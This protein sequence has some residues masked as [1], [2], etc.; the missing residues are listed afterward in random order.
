[1]E[2]LSL[3]NRRIVTTSWDD[4]DR[5]DLKLAELLQSK[6]I[7]ATFYVPTGSYRKQAL[8]AAD[9][10]VLSS[11]GFEI[12]AHGFSHKLLKGLSAR[13]LEAEI[14]S[15]KP[16][17][18][19]LTG[20]E[21]RMFCYPCGQYDANAIRAVK[22]AGYSGA[23][24]VRMLAT[25]HDFDSFRMPTTVQSFP[26]PRLTYL[27]NAAKAGKMEGLRVCL[28]NGTRLGNWLELGKKLFD[29]VVEKGGIWHLYGH[30]WEIEE[31]GLWKDLGELLDYV[32][33]RSDVTYV[34]N[35]KLVPGTAANL[36]LEKAC[37]V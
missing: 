2:T 7:R 3:E 28:A 37:S 30:S 21:V 14:N 25:E 5:L 10:R 16:T 36:R 33:K 35:S 15:C 18:E 11:A 17:L 27:K 20:R 19:D 32:G 4:G 1:M 22:A 8:S 24:T 13:E 26:H 6:A 12:G 23:R 31:L 29:S 9:L 34:P